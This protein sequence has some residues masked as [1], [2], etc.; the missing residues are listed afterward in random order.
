MRP[1]QQLAFILEIDK[2]KSIIRQTHLRDG[3]RL[4]NSAEHSWHLA[5]MA[6]LLVEYAAE[7]VDCLRVLKMLLI[8]D[9]VEVD[10]GDTFAYD[11]AGN[12]TKAQRE[13][14][15]AERLFGLLPADQGA[16]FRQLWDEFEAMATPESRYANAIDRIQ[17]LMLNYHSGGLGWRRHSVT[18]GQVRKRVRAVHD[19]A[20]ELGRMAEDIIR[21]AVEKGYLKEA[22]ATVPPSQAGQ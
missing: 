2:L 5:V 15:A 11:D 16:E 22:A 17:P 10:A 7:P 13:Q 20:P 8:H 9:V 3:S 6:T 4:E 1:E 12:G 18:A 19:G 21:R 14:A